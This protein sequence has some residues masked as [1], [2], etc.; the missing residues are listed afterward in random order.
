MT[1]F[2]QGFATYF[3]FNSTVLISH[4]LQTHPM[5]KHL[6]SMMLCCLLSFTAWTQSVSLDAVIVP[7]K[8]YLCAGKNVVLAYHTDG[9]FNADNKFTIQLVS[10]TSISLE[11]KDSSGFLVGKIPASIEDNLAGPFTPVYQI[12]IISSS[13]VVNSSS[14][15]NYNIGILP[16]LT[17]S[18][19]KIYT[20]QGA[21]ASISLEG[22]PYLPLPMTFVSSE[23]EIFEMTSV[24]NPG[25]YVAYM[26]P[27]KTGA[28]SFKSVQNA[29]GVGKITGSVD[30]VSTPNILEYAGFGPKTFCKGG[31]VSFS[32]NTFGTW[33]NGNKFY[34]ELKLNETKSY[35]LEATLKDNIVTAKLPDDIEVEK[36]YSARIY[37]TS[38]ETSSI[39]VNSVL[40][41][42]VSSVEILDGSETLNVGYSTSIPLVAKGPV[43]ITISMSDGYKLV[44]N[45][46]EKD[47]WYHKIITGLDTIR[48]K[49]FSNVCGS[50]VGKGQFIINCKPSITLK[51]NLKKSY[52]PGDSMLVTFFSSSILSVDTEINAHIQFGGVESSN[53]IILLGK[54]ISPGVALFILPKVINVEAQPFD[55]AIFSSLYPTK[56]FFKNISILRNIPKV[57]RLRSLMSS[58]TNIDP[59]V[60]N[61]SINV[62]GGG[63]YNYI[64]SLDEVH[65]STSEAL[66]DTLYVKSQINR[67]TEFKITNISNSCGTSTIGSNVL[68]ITVAR[69]SVVKL[70]APF[71]NGDELCVGARYTLRINSTVAVPI[72][73]KFY[74]AYFVESGSETRYIMEE[75]VNNQLEWTVPNDSGI[76]GNLY[77]QVKS[78]VSSIIG[79]ELKVKIG[80]KPEEDVALKSYTFRSP[81]TFF[82]NVVTHS[83]LRSV[84]TTSKN[85]KFYG[86][87]RI[88]ANFGSDTT[89]VYTIKSIA[90]TCGE[91]M[92]KV[93]FS[94][95]LVP[96]KVFFYK[97]APTSQPQIVCEGERVSFSY[98]LNSLIGKYLREDSRT[99]RLEMSNNVNFENRV[100][101]KSSISESQ[102]SVV[103][104]TTT[105]SGTN[106]IRLVQEQDTLIMTDS[107]IIVYRR[108]PN[109][110]VTTST[111]KTDFNL[112]YGESIQ[113]KVDN[114]NATPFDGFWVDNNNYYTSILEFQYYKTFTPVRSGTYKLNTLYNECGTSDNGL[115][116]NVTVNPKITWSA[117]L[118]NTTINACNGDSFLVNINA[119]GSE[120]VSNKYSL[121]MNSGALQQT[122]F[123]TTKTG[124]QMVTIPKSVDAG[125]YS[126]VLTAQS[127]T[128]TSANT[129]TLVNLS[130]TPALVLTGTATLNP[131]QTAYLYLKPQVASIN[132]AYLQTVSYEL[133]DGTKGT[134][135]YSAISP[136]AIP[137]TVTGT[138]SFTVTKVSNQCGVGV[139]SGSATITLNASSDKTIET[140]N[141]LVN[142]QVI[143]KVC[144]GGNYVISYNT[145]GTF[146]T[147]AKFDVQISDKNG[148]NFKT[149]S[150]DIVSS[151][152]NTLSF[153]VPFDLPA[154]S[155]YH[156]KVIS[157]EAN[158]AS[159]STTMPLTLSSI[160]RAEFDTTQYYFT[161]DKPVSL[162]VNLLGK[163]PFYVRLGETWT[164]AKVYTVNTL[165]FEAS[166]TPT[167]GTSYQIFEVA[168][169][170][171]GLGTV[172]A[173]NIAK[174]AV[175]TGI[176]DLQ[177]L[178]VLVGPNPTSDFITITSDEPNVKAEIFDMLGQSVFDAEL[179]AGKNQISL[180]SFANGV[181][182]LKVSKGNKSGTFKLM[183]F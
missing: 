60:F 27:Q 40:I 128:I 181:Y 81:S 65:F 135:Q 76:L 99:Y 112:N 2:L 23:N 49:S 100:I 12:R 166:V 61:Y 18:S 136:G 132:D 15:S 95:R 172:G 78:N 90:N 67:S 114:P 73:T 82:F 152:P 176:D 41:H 46:M 19:A 52:C 171:C 31:N 109:L 94:F 79:D 45:T 169:G 11:T 97:S 160:I 125:R 134:V 26:H 63:P 53:D 168:N 137:V 3:P 75:F 39:T 119:Q 175:I 144:A 143:S 155:D 103:L 140:N 145:K 84:L 118:A 127:G 59:G 130:S 62:S 148:Q 92:P 150:S 146:S 48:I 77:L 183:K 157:S 164:T 182:H 138:K 147:N 8:E 121:I 126:L 131:S 72:G 170:E 141:I 163:T 174:L 88:F 55:L 123:E 51:G 70:I 66:S 9:A 5:I 101:I 124:P 44:V 32:V 102:F 122:I 156:V 98:Y 162:K 178:G 180:Q 24:R 4:L 165:P 33:Q 14:T 96:D 104:P 28:F 117:S 17:V 56:T 93:S 57:G 149:V 142:K 54:V 179:H 86:D 83:P 37:A 105:T 115:T 38:P 47:L 167:T 108:V 34:I 159:S 89:V 173:K 58:L 69:P 158:T 13:P 74:L 68:N 42:D 113:L 43:P 110:K 36:Y 6:L 7:S 87:S 29:C 25:A 129:N 107:D 20:L 22:R 91:I 71:N 139:V 85:T 161:T 1:C 151:T 106:Y 21:A 120:N 154:G 111:G 116:L 50:G 153:S 30:I 64:T 177:S 16:V 133:N 80:K 10:N 35:Q